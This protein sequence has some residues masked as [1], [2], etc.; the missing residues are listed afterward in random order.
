MENLVEVLL[1]EDSLNTYIVSQAWSHLLLDKIEV[2]LENG[3]SK[4]ER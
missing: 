2:V 1:E 4:L 3:M